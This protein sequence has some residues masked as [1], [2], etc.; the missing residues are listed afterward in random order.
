VDAWPHLPTNAARQPQ[1]VSKTTTAMK[2]FLKLILCLCATASA[3]LASDFK[4]VPAIREAF[5]KAGVTGTFVMLDPADNC[6]YGHDEG[7][8]RTRF[9]P[10]STFKIANSLIGLDC[11]AISGMDEVLP[12][13]GKPQPFKEWE[14]DMA[15]REAIKVSNVPVYQELARRIG[16]KHMKAGV[17][18]LNYGNREIGDV[19][20]NFW[21]VGPLKISAVE[22]V[23][24]LRRV[25]TG[26]LP[27]SPQTSGAVQEITLLES[28]DKGLLHGKTGWTTASSPGIG[29]FVG[30][31]ER[32]R[33]I[34][35]FALN[36]DMP[37]KDSAPKR[38][39]L[40]KECLSI[41][42]KY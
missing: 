11:G 42:G 27:V 38:I 25:A 37:S 32:S 29:W 9:V 7:R 39:P 18:K 40:A 36:I 31:V 10:A 19:V 1:Q 33:S 41:L 14:H 26:D 13:G 17:K 35:P 21:L 8:A 30:W 22:Q 24:F 5:Q 34:Y 28:T 15:L 12:Y 16:M 3:A 2:S 23:A 20:D 6:L 4:E